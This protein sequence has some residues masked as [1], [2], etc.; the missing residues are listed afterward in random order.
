VG[1]IGKLGAVPATLER[2]I[3]H[4]MGEKTGKVHACLRLVRPVTPQAHSQT[5][6]RIENSM[7]VISVIY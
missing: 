2:L 6:K 5:P 1:L 4:A 3:A 7:M